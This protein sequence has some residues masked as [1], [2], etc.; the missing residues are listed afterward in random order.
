MKQLSQSKE[1]LL[2]TLHTVSV[3]IPCRNEE[4]N[5]EDAI[6]RCPEMGI[7]TEFVFVEGHSTDGTVAE[8]KC[9]ATQY[10]DKDIKFFVQEG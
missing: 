8:I 3:I 7:S 10:S 1:H 9:V 2:S 6:K 4:G 5:I